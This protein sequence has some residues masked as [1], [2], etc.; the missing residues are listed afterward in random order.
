MTEFAEPAL[1][2]WYRALHSPLGVEVVVSDQEKARQKL[3]AARKESRDPDLERIS[4]CL[5]PFDPMKIWL[6]KKEPTDASS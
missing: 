5:S 1:N 4:I 3:Y 2:Y 6:V